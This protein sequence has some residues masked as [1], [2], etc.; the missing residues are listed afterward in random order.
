MEKFIQIK[1][2]PNYEISDLGNIRNTKTKRV[3]KTRKSKKKYVRVNLS[4]NTKQYTLLLHR[5]VALTHISNP[6]NF[7]FVDHMDRDRQN[8]N[9]S[10]LRWV[11][12]EV[13]MDNRLYK[14]T[15]LYYCNLTNKFIIQNVSNKTIQQFECINS[16]F[17]AFSNVYKLT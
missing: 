5:L 10:N 2:Y 7:E 12:S 9:A 1:E 14:R 15:C 13:N 3:L 11:S 8:N 6:E 17:T 4:K 16:A